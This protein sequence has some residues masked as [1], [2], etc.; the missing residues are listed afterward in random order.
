MK[1]WNY[2]EKMSKKKTLDLQSQN[3][4]VRYANIFSILV[5]LIKPKFLFAIIGRGGGKTTDI[6]APRIIDI[7]YDMPGCYVALAADTYM[8]AMKNVLPAII[9]GWERNDWVEDIHFVVGKRPPK[10]FKKP[11]K[12]PQD[13][14]H[15]IT[16]LTGM[17]IILISMDRPSTGAGNSF[18]HIISDETKFI[19]EKKINKL[20]PA[21]R[22]E[23]VRFSKSIYYRGRTFTTDMPNINNREHD[24]ILRMKKNMNPDQIKLILQTAFVLNDIRVELHNA[25]EQKELVKIKLLEKNEQRWLDRYHKIRTES[26]FYYEGSSYLNAD[27]LT[28]GFFQDLLDT[29]LFGEFKTSVLSIQPTLEKGQMFYP[30]LSQKNYYSDSYNYGYYDKLSLNK[31]GVEESSLGLKYVQGNNPLEIGLDVGN[32]CSLSIGQPFGTQYRILK[33]MH[34]LAPEYLTE[35][36]EKF[37]SFF[38]HQKCKEVIA[39]HDRSANQNQ[40][41]GEDHASKFKKAIEYD[42]DGKPTGWICTLMSKNQATISQQVEYELLL[43]MLVGSHGLPMVMIDK[44]ECKPLK[45]SLEKAQIIVKTDKNGNKTIHK[46]K[47]S[48]KLPIDRLPMESTNPSDSTKYLLC[49]PE[50]LNKIKGQELTWHSDPSAH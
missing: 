7:S 1:P 38:E 24:W 20:T 8:N 12:P 44:N 46:D 37:R 42:R 27:I 36:G 23:F 17:H 26:T 45:S 6:I 14:K 4:T 2:L 18:Q 49:R 30:N 41:V 35:L 48:E 19:P 11:Y 5:Q 15:T 47:T 40:S 9:E 31:N 16:T 22:G 10:H 29:M 13:W 28:E 32:M 3:V 50:F 33:F 39:Y 34:T 25:R 21:I 43:A